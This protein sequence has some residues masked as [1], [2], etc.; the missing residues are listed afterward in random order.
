MPLERQG[1]QDRL[2]PLCR[3]SWALRLVY[4]PE[5]GDGENE[6]RTHNR[7]EALAPNSCDEHHE[8]RSG[9]EG[10]R[11]T[12]IGLCKYEEA[13]HRD[14]P[15]DGQEAAEGFLKSREARGLASEE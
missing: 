11:G 10:E 13:R 2:P 12:K 7:K 9:D 4:G 1:L 8:E 5:D 14:Q 3:G 6:K 15:A